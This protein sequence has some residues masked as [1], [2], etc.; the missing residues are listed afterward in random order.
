MRRLAFFLL[1]LLWA[2]ACQPT[3]TPVLP[4]LAVLPT[5]P[6][7]TTPLP[8]VTPL[9]TEVAQAVPETPS[10]TPTD[11]P[12]DTPTE[13][14]TQ[15]PTAAD[16][17]TPLPSFTPQPSLTDTP[18]P[19][20]TR[21]P[22]LTITNTITNT[23]SR[24]F[25]ATLPVEGMGMLAELGGRTTILPPEQLYNPPTLTAFAIAQQTQVAGR[26]IIVPIQNLTPTPVFGFPTSV[27]T[28]FGGIP[29]AAVTC[30]TPPPAALA[31]LFATDPALSGQIGCPIGTT[32]AQTVTAAQLFER[33]MMVYV[34]G[35]P[36]TIYSLS[37]DGTFRR[38]SDTFAAGVDPE[39]GGETPP[40]GLL[41]PVRGFGKVWRS[42][43]D[44]RAALGWAIIPEQGD[45]GSQLLSFD[46]GRAIF[47]PQRSQTVLLIDDL[48][49]AGGRW[50]SIGGSF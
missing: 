7:S 28:S 41:E 38:F 39:S 29:T 12:T 25:T 10:A 5:L 11:T 30:T 40:S 43:P 34:A 3:P 20:V 24:T 26:G 45:A 6:P 31:P 16:T 18:S 37:N 49:G 35:S 33:G 22:S 27:A 9:P 47:L 15:A 44:V 17:A 19:T 14:P 32:P 13:A 42:N 4:T 8:S 1:I 46:R 36:G 21:T 48:G 2:A 50:R 23:P